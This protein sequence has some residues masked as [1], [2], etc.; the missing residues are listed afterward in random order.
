M[1]YSLVLYSCYQQRGE[2]DIGH[3]PVEEVH[4]VVG[5]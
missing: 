2:Q 3:L 1:S 5:L 4:S